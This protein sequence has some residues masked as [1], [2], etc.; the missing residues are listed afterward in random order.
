MRT[1]T[2]SARFTFALALLI[3]SLAVLWFVAVPDT[4][5]PAS[6]LF[7]AALL[8]G[9]G[10]VG[11]TT[12][13][14]TEPARSIARVLYRADFTPARATAPVRETAPGARRQI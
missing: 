5:T 4:L 11:L 3:P 9:L 1:L 13:G 14:N 8:T 10:A 12:Y 6:Y 7:L 2:D